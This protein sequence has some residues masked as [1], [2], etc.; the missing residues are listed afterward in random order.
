MSGWTSLAVVMI[1]ILFAAVALAWT[2][3]RWIVVKVEGI[4]MLPALK[5]GDVI[6]A[7]RCQGDR[8]CR[9]DIVIFSQ[10]EALSELITR[11]GGSRISISGI[12]VKRV[13]ATPGDAV[14]AEF[15]HAVTPGKVVP[16]SRVIV[17]SDNDGLDSRIFGLLPYDRVLGMF[18]RQLPRV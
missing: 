4:S 14:P 16:E 11:S 9:G 3:R 8:L 12:L 1:T 15:V 17:S 18:I 10:P 6:L 7:R 2:R 13:A 5:H